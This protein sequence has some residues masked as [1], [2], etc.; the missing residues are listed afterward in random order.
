[1]QVMPKYLDL[2]IL[3]IYIFTHLP[4]IKWHMR[5]RRGAHLFPSL[6]HGPQLLHG[7]A[8]AQWT[9]EL[10]LLRLKNNGSYLPVIPSWWSHSASHFFIIYEVKIVKSEE[11]IHESFL[12]HFSCRGKECQSMKMEWTW[13][14]CS[15]S[16]SDGGT[17]ASTTGDS[18]GWTRF[19][20]RAQ[21]RWNLFGPQSGWGFVWTKKLLLKMAKLLKV[22]QEDSRGYLI[23]LVMPFFDHLSKQENQDAAG[24][25][26]W[27]SKRNSWEES[28]Q[29]PGSSSP[30]VSGFFCPKWLLE[31][32]RFCSNF[33]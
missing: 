26:T 29:N 9:H 4:C 22:L 21:G 20:P 25:R 1:M 5:L 15:L 8:G 19:A 12:P 30:F 10:G 13:M 28:L 33:V 31:L 17:S 14:R 32:L 11:H 24:S 18:W 2:C 3:Y 23:L 27:L 16:L 6:H 7:L